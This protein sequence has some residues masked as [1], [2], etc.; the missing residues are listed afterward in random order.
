MTECGQPDFV[1]NFES[2][3]LF[4]EERVWFQNFGK[5][6]LLPELV[7]QM[8]PFV[9]YQYSGFNGLEYRCGFYLP[10]WYSGCIVGSC[11]F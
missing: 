1:Y 11:Q 10:F 7:E 8:L 6:H 2:K 3:C 5:V 9:V 4:C